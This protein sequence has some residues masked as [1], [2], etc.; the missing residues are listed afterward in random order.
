MDARAGT[1]PQPHDPTVG[2]LRDAVHSCVHCNL[3]KAAPLYRSALAVNPGNY[4]A[5]CR[6]GLVRAQCRAAFVR[7]DIAEACN[8][9]GLTLVQRSYLMK[10]IAEY[11]PA[12][13]LDSIYAASLKNLATALS[14][15]D[16]H[17]EA[18][19]AR[20]FAA[21]NLN[22]GGTL[23][24]LN[25]LLEAQVTHE[26]ALKHRRA[27]VKCAWAV[28]MIACSARTKR[29]GARPPLVK[30]SRARSTAACVL[31]RCF[32]PST[33]SCLDCKPDTNPPV[34]LRRLRLL[35][36]AVANAAQSP[37]RCARYG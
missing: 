15:S 7:A 12:L 30:V 13:R 21:A 10:R 9:L 8:S 2:S 35:T 3:A 17:D 5:T 20:R 33:F 11:E 31:A 18:A 22:L 34:Y 4:P 24:L 1:K 27:P 32:R 37:A 36:A 16:G 6:L 26:T 29:L 19:V 28:S 14:S 25:K 23:A